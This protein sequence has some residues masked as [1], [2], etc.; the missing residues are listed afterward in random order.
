M[1]TSF[2][3]ASTTCTVGGGGGGGALLW[4]APTSRI[5]PRMTRGLERDIRSEACRRGRQL[6]RGE[7]VP[8]EEERHSPV[9]PRRGLLPAR[10]DAGTAEIAERGVTGREQARGV[11]DAEVHLLGRTV[12]AHEQRRQAHGRRR[13]IETA[14]AGVRTC[15]DGRRAAGEVDRI[16]AAV[17]EAALVSSPVEREDGD[18]LPGGVD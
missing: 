2:C 11:G 4:Q 1:G 9:E 12:N 5:E 15:R 13:A 6:D 14:L 16:G 7:H 3:T 10:T 18:Q 8:A 17:E